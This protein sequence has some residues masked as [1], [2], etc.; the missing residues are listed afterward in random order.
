ML[1]SG[2]RDI[3]TTDA[4]QA[5]PAWAG[6]DHPDD[7]WVELPN[8]GHL[9]FIS[10]CDDIG[11][12]FLDQFQPNNQED[13]CGDDFVPV[14][15][16]VPALAAYLLGFARLHV[17]GEEVWRTILGGDPLDPAVVVTTR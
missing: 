5:Q 7:I 16:A 17:L 14:S 10:V 12:N 2:R 15:Q 4:A 1:Q 3:T 6:L 8:G 9:S 13:G 11:P